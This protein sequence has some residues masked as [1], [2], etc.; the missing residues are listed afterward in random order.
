MIKTIPKKYWKHKKSDKL[1]IS[2]FRPYVNLPSE[3]SV[4]ISSNNGDFK[5]TIK[6]RE[7]MK[8][9]KEVLTFVLKSKPI[10]E[11]DYEKSRKKMFGY[12]KKDDPIFKEKK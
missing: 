6:N 2:G 11:E 7:D 3:G 5:L 10:T 4:S 9:L 1:E 8:N 12:V